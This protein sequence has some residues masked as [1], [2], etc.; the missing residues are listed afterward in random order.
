M[1][2]YSLFRLLSQKTFD[3]F[4][5]D[6]VSVAREIAIIRDNDLTLN[7]DRAPHMLM[8][9]DNFGFADGAPPLSHLLSAG[10][11]SVKKKVVV[12]PD[13][14]LHLRLPNN[15]I[16]RGLYLALLTSPPAKDVSKTLKERRADFFAALA[17]KRVF[18][19]ETI[20]R[21]FLS[22][23]AQPPDVGDQEYFEQ[24]IYLIARYLFQ[25]FDLP[26]TPMLGVV[27]GW[28]KLI[29]GDFFLVQI[30]NADPDWADMTPEPFDANGRLNP[31][32]EMPPEPRRLYEEDAE[33]A[34]GDDVEAASLA[35]KRR[36]AIIDRYL[37]LQAQRGVHELEEKDY[38]AWFFPLATPSVKVFLVGLSIYKRELVRVVIKQ[39]TKKVRRLAK[40]I[41]PPEEQSPELASEKQSPELQSE[42]RPPEKEPDES[43]ESV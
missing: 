16:G 20:F 23:V 19:L 13:S 27:E 10:F 38:A 8:R 36:I 21:R 24:K 29:A 11:M 2:P 35:E 28:T 6:R 12:V 42:E 14:E 34:A 39:A 25:P 37:D 3:S 26:E 41:L 22:T 17:E 15:E 33:R 7:L 32:W 18:A 43:S 4:W 30:R 5:F 40:K 31:P 1:N 9:S